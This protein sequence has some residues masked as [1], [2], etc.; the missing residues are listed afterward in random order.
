MPTGES[1]VALRKKFKV[2]PKDYK[3]IVKST[4]RGGPCTLSDEEPPKADYMG[5]LQDL[6][7]QVQDELSR[8]LGMGDLNITFERD[9]CVVLDLCVGGDGNTPEKRSCFGIV[10][11]MID[12]SM[13][14]IKVGVSGKL[15]GTSTWGS[16]K[17]WSKQAGVFHRELRKMA[18]IWLRLSDTCRVRFRIQYRNG[19]MSWLWKQEGLSGSTHPHRCPNCDEHA[20]TWNK[21]LHTTANLRTPTC[22]ALDYMT[23]LVKVLSA[24]FAHGARGA[25][26][27]KTNMVKLLAAYNYNK[28]QLSLSLSLSLYVYIC[29][30]MCIY[31]CVCVRARAC[32]CVRARARARVCVCVCVCVTV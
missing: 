12:P 11:W 6:R 29:A 19:D 9:T 20:K 32:V 5:I 23:S 4:V 14:V 21:G 18:A 1:E 22:L 28:V 31:A 10:F 30:Y 16:E 3:F 27:A 2:L 17:E 13:T 24:V 25:K 8:L 26:M 15:S 7:K